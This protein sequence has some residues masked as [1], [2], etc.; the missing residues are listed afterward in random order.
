VKIKNGKIYKITNLIN[1]KMYI[2]LTTE[3]ISVRWSGHKAY[4]KTENNIYLYNSMNKYGIEN[5]KIETL[6]TGVKS[7]SKLYELEKLYI[8][9]YDT[10]NTGYNLTLGGEGT[11]GYR[12]TEDTKKKL[13]K[14]KI[15]RKLSPEHRKISLKTLELGSKPGKDHPSSIGVYQICK[16]TGGVI[17]YHESINLAEQELSGTGKGSG[18]I[19]KVVNGK[20]KSAYG[21]YWKTKEQMK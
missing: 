2:G 6:V 10:F 14:A 3:P 4:S 18:S 9:K 13:S 12:H 21:Y 16:R 5:F 19:C 7:M 15:G 11:V 20:R 1:N 17:R 8:K